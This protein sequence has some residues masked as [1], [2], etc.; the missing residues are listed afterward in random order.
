MTVISFSIDVN[1]ERPVSVKSESVS[2][3][4]K[5]SVSEIPLFKP[6][7]RIM[8]R[9]LSPE[10][11]SDMLRESPPYTIHLEFDALPS[12]LVSGMLFTPP[13]SAPD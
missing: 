9:A 3:Y 4:G 2:Y 6:R 11:I 10:Q 13:I 5:S 7:A 8:S 1:A 12:N